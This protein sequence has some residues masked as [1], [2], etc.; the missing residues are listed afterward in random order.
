M[1]PKKR[2]TFALIKLITEAPRSQT[3]LIE[4]TGQY[5]DRVR[6]TMRGLQAEG[7]ITPCGQRATGNRPQILFRWCAAQ[8][9]TA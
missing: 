3:E 2:E 8:E 9:A 6:D 4:L 5:E 1:T 7:L